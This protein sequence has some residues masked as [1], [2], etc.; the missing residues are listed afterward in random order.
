MRRLAR[1]LRDLAARIDWEGAPKSA[2]W[3]FTI[4][5]G[6]GIVFREDGRGCPLWYLGE[7]DYLRAHREAGPVPGEGDQWQRSHRHPYPKQEGPES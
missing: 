6:R 3:S 5:P 4:E 7:E 2:H 1:W